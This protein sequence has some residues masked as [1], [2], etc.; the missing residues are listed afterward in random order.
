MCGISVILA[1]RSA[2]TSRLG[3]EI[4]KMH[5]VAEHRGPDGDAFLEVR[6][7]GTARRADTIGDVADAAAVGAFRWLVVQDAS[8]AA[9]Q[10][11]PSHDGRTWLLF[12]G[13]VYNY[14]ELGAELRELGHRFETGSDTEVILAAY[15][16]WGTRCFARFNGMW[17]VVLF[18]SVR[19]RVVVSRD[20]LGIRPLFY[21]RDRG[22]LLFASEVKQILA[23]KASAQPHEHYVR[24]YLETG[25]LMHFDQATFFDG[26]STVPPATFVEID[27][28]GEG[29]LAF[30]PYWRLRDFQSGNG[31]RRDERE[32]RAH[33]EH[34]LQASVRRMRRTRAPAGTFLSGGL[35]SSVLTALIAEEERAT[36]PS[37][38]IVFDRSRYGAFDESAY[39]D[40]F[41]AQ[42]GVRNERATLS[43]SWIR[44]NIAAVTRAHEE[45][46]VATAQMAQYRA[47]QLAREHGARVIYDGQG[48]DELLAGY[49][50]HEWI[51]WR[52]RVAHGQFVRAAAEARILR[53]KYRVSL[54]EIFVRRLLRQ[55][56]RR[57]AD[58]RGW[59]R[60]SYGFIR[61]T[62][63]ANVALL[64]AREAERLIARDRGARSTAI[65]RE[66]YRDLTYY[67]LRPSLL[68]G[69]RV[70]MAHSIE[71]RL[72]YL[73]L[74]LVQFVAGVPDDMHVGFGE[75]KKLLR[76][77]AAGRVP[78]SILDRRDKMGF[79]TP[80]SE[81]LRTD[82][83][84]DVRSAVSDPRLRSAGIIDQAA[85]LRFVEDYRNGTHRDFRAVWRLY[86]LPAWLDAFRMW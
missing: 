12:N 68:N 2:E 14:V 21:A 42:H 59:F 23:V 15:A 58:D 17:A 27:L 22:R 29:D 26:V 72:P 24:H 4:L 66:I 67:L 52:S 76:A 16:Q 62:A 6:R 77:A 3:T 43:P 70:G 57:A 51:R 33:F 37:F 74:E 84:D 20:P 78:K 25:T 1:L 49:P 60:K 69:D 85:A 83:M 39:I 28:D 86:A 7:D 36:L 30:Q 44:E 71:S 81:W 11:M 5:S 55:P 34:L 56:L 45:P 73:D 50:E 54:Y 8:P 10:P 64:R 63:S 13:E 61:G 35:D 65:A 32:T 31:D 82:L 46:L 40:D 75:R 48:S 38:S 9:S 53:R 19:R 18:D 47:F 79:V 41:V 80:E